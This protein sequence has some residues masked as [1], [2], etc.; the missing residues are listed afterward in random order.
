MPI[1]KKV[2]CVIIDEIQLAA[3][4][5]RGHVFT[6]RLLNLRGLHETIFLGSLTQVLE[7]HRFI[8]TEKACSNFVP[9]LICIILK[10]VVC[11]T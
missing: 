8:G 4:Y 1:T 3:D 2:D 9:E 7:I 6:D 5:E 10:R 11:T